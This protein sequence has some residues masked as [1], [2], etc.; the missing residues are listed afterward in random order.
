MCH[1]RSSALLM[2]APEVQL[3]VAVTAADRS[4]TVVQEQFHEFVPALSKYSSVTVACTLIVIGALGL[5]EVWE[6]SR[7][8]ESPP[9]M[10]GTLHVERSSLWPQHDHRF[11]S[12]VRATPSHTPKSHA[13]ERRLRSAGQ[14]AR[15][16]R[17]MPPLAWITL[18]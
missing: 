10:A 15:A 5:K 12:S 13:F 4:S 1:K 11:C 16:Q 6:E 7:H 18:Q 9:A 2:P 8:P 17:T 3:L 14:Q